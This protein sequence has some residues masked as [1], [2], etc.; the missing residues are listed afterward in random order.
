MRYF[1]LFFAQF[2]VLSAMSQVNHSSVS[3]QEFL[4][5]ESI[6]GVIVKKV[7]LFGDQKLDFDSTKRS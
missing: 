5:E 3:K 7:V 2:L 4:D 6:R 1:L